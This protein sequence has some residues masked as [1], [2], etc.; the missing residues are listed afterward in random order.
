MSKKQ[1]FYIIF[2]TVLVLAFFGTLSAVIPG[3]IKPKPR[4]IS[5]V[6]PFAF[7]NQEGQFVTEKDV[8]GKVNAVN[9]FFTTCTSVCP[10]MN[11]NFKDVYDQFKNEPDFLMLSYTSD[12]ERDTVGRLKHYADSMKVNASKW[13]FLTGRKDSLYAM[14]RHSY[15]LDDPNNFVPDIKHDFLHTQFIALVNRKGEVVQIYDG[16]KP[17]EMKQME[18]EI[19]KL[20]KE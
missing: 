16:L 3:F 12:P 20:L 1:V 14:A 2:F 17:S 7:H 15:A 9:F 11:N 8:I 13:I 4:P 19:K 5:I 6:Q 10:R 18:D